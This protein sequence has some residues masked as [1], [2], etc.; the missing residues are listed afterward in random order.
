MRGLLGGAALMLL[1][2]IADDLKDIPPRLKLLGQILCACVAW[3]FTVRILGM[4]NLFGGAYISFSP[5]V[6][7]IVTVLWIVAITNTINLIDGLDGLAGGISCI[8]ALTAAYTAYMTGNSRTSTLMLAIAGATFGFLLWNFYP[9]KIFMG[10]AG[11]M[12]LGYLLST[13]SLIGDYPTKGTTLFATIT[14]MLILALPIFDTVF[15]IIRR[16]AN[17]QPIMKADKGHLHHRIMRMGF[18]QRRTVLALYSIS[19]IMGMAGI[20][21]TI[22][23]KLEA[24]V[25]AGIAAVLIVVFLGIG[26]KD[27]RRPPREASEE[28]LANAPQSYAD[29]PAFG[30]VPPRAKDSAEKGPADK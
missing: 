8:A 23:R 24:V 20:L 18:G 7:L 11:S 28:E 10:D 29:A 16:A 17:H 5:P 25:L 2:G 9:A 1:L 6:S 15:A 12:V 30:H 19:A 27:L 22:R 14:P 3:F 4:A 26:V 21:W 13:V